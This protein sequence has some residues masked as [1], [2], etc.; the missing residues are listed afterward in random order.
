MSIEYPEG[1][2]PLDPDEMEGL[3]FKHVTTRGELDHLEQGNIQDGLIWLQRNKDTD[4]LNEG[5][6]RTLHKHLFGAV[7]NW[8]GTLRKREKS[9]GVVPLQIGVH[10]RMLLDDALVWIENDTYE[11]LQTAVRIHYRLVYV[12]LFPNGKGRHARIMADALL[13]EKFKLQPVDWA[14]GYDLQSMTERRTQYIQALRAADGGDI[15]PLMTMFRM[16]DE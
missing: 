16:T 2:T 4:I 5:F 14:G 7:L 13:T 15:V 1:A 11:P 8:A 9:I 3:K 6:V 10:L 12:H